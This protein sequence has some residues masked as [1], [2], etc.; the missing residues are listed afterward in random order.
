MKQKGQT[1]SNTSSLV[2]K[3]MIKSSNLSNNN[4]T[5]KNFNTNLINV[6]N[7]RKHKDE[8]A[9]NILN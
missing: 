3:G 5:K 2:S 8:A 6:K 9:D 1:K 7:K 4:L